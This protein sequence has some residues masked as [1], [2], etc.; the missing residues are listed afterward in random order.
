MK[1]KSKKKSKKKI[2]KKRKAKNY[3][4]QKGNG[5][6]IDLQKVLDFKFQTLDKIYKNFTKKQRTS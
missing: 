4:K 1:K 5:G 6:G 2:V 3:S